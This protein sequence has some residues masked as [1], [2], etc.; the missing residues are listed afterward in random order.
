[1]N[2]SSYNN[3][4]VSDPESRKNTN[5]TIEPLFVLLDERTCGKTKGDLGKAQD[6][7]F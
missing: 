3:E 1:L 7:T 2:P 5:T 6:Q 4:V